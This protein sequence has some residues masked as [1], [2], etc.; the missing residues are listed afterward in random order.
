MTTTT[1]LTREVLAEMLTEPTGRNILD[2]GDHYGRHWE[3]NA[4]ATLADWEAGPRAWVTRWGVSVSTFHYLAERLEYDP[5]WNRAWDAYC[6]ANHD[7]G[8]L[9]LME[10]FANDRDASAQTFN[11]YNTGAEAITQTLQGTLF[12]SHDNVLVILQ[13]HGGCDVRGGYTRP[14]VFRVVTDEPTYF[15]YDA[16]HYGL[17]CDSGDETHGLNYSGE[18]ISWEGSSV[19]DSSIPTFTDDEHAVCA[20]CGSTMTPHAPAPY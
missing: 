20:L 11:T 6:K 9:T 7:A 2:S 15:T 12:S 3:R 5:K 14:R 4:G 1:T 16:S 17:T 19:D 18:W 10:G 13:I 8:W